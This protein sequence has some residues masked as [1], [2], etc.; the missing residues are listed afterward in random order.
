[1]N[2]HWYTI[3]LLARERQA[4]L[5]RE[6]ETARLLRGQDLAGRGNTGRWRAKLALALFCAIPAIL[7]IGR[8]VIA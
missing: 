4:E 3:E 6:A 8:A 2:T 5:R 7:L 1:M